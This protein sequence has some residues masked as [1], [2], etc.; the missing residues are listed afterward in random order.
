MFYVKKAI[1]DLNNLINTTR[2]DLKDFDTHTAGEYE[3]WELFVNDFNKICLFKDVFMKGDI[4]QSLE[5]VSTC[6]TSVREMIP[7]ST[8]ELIGGKLIHAKDKSFDNVISKTTAYQELVSHIFK[9]YENKKDATEYEEKLSSIIEPYA[10]NKITSNPHT[11]Q[12]EKLVKR[13]KRTI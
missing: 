4:K 10:F 12:S 6:E 11:E 7:S 2:E 1:D 5:Y 3:I 8:Y 13:I 9:I